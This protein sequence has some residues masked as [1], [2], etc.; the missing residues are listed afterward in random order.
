[1]AEEEE[2]LQE[3]DHAAE[4]EVHPVDEVAEGVVSIEAL[5]SRCSRLLPTIRLSKDSY[6]A[7]FSI[8]TFL[9]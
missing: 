6:V 3:V 5:P 4:A 7:K 8:K 2:D 1:M 9:F